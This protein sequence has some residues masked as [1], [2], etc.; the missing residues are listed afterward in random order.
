MTYFQTSWSSTF[1]GYSWSRSQWLTGLSSLFRLFPPLCGTSH[2]P[3]PWG[4][5]PAVDNAQ[6]YQATYL[7]TVHPEAATSNGSWVVTRTW[8]AGWGDQ[9]EERSHPLSATCQSPGRN[10]GAVTSCNAFIF[11]RCPKASHKFKLWY[12]IFWL[13]IWQLICLCK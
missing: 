3:A 6:W 2:P 10:P 5:G 11:Q 9:R 12:E 8:A 13:Y 1:L 7:S 4:P